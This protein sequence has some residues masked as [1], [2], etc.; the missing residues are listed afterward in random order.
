MSKLNLQ[1]LFQTTITSL[2]SSSASD[3]SFTIDTAPNWVWGYIEIDQE[4]SAK[5]EKFKYYNVS[6]NTVYYRGVDR[7]TPV[8][9]T[10]WATVV[11]K[12]FSFFFNHL[13]D[14]I[15]EQFKIE[16]K[17]LLDILVWGGEC[18]KSDNSLVT[19]SDTT[20]SL[21]ASNTN[22]IYLDTADDT[23]KA[24]IVEATAWE[25]WIFGEVLTDATSA[26]TITSYNPKYVGG[27]SKVFDTTTTLKWYN[28]GALCTNTSWAITYSLP[29]ATVWLSF[30]FR[31]GNNNNL[32]IDADWTDI[33]SYSGTNGS[34][35]GTAIDNITGEILEIKCFKA[36]IWAVTGIEW[37]WTLS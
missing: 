31:V 16:K 11:I 20:L 7:P 23:L 27:K 33:F 32:I 14:L 5:A 24:T 36:W 13:N 25:G 2:I 17:W 19:I 10:S 12:D 3:G 8:E 37:S 22:Y 6:W 9:H 29:S 30:S 4:D 21:T 26:T 35:G 15:W 18:I 34:A 28:T 1:D